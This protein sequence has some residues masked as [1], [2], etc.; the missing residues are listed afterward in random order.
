MYKKENKIT[1]KCKKTKDCKTK[2]DPNDDNCVKC[3]TGQLCNK[4]DGM[5]CAEFESNL[6]E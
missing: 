6:D 2:C 5:L 4:D 1:K 3:C